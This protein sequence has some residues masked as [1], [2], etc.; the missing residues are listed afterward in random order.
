MAAAVLGPEKFQSG[1]QIYM[2]RHKY[3]NTITIDLWN[4]WSL[5]SGIDMPALMTSWTE[6]MGYPYLTVTG[7]RYN[8]S[9]K[10]IEIDLEQNCKF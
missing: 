2:D 8:D 5:A 1:L 7:E 10:T 6:Q 3:S 9:S 4:A